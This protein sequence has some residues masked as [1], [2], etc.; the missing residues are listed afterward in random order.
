MKSHLTPTT[1]SITSRTTSLSET[2]KVAITCPNKNVQERQ[3]P[4]GGVEQSTVE[5]EE[6]EQDRAIVV[7]EQSSHTTH[8]ILKYQ[9]VKR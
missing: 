6:V 2:P 1:Y 4:W 7:Q 3:K 9:Q 5:V 8:P